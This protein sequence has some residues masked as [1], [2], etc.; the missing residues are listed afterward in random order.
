MHPNPAGLPTRSAQNPTRTNPKSPRSRKAS[1][2]EGAALPLFRGSQRDCRLIGW[3][4]FRLKLATVTQE[5]S[6]FW[7]APG[8]S[9]AGPSPS[10][11]L[12]PG[13]I[14]A[15]IRDVVSSEVSVG[16]REK[17][18]LAGSR[19]R[20]VGFTLLRKQ[21]Q[22]WQ[23]AS[24]KTARSSPVCGTSRSLPGSCPH[25]ARGRLHTTPG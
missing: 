9:G 21:L 16:Q 14:G 19:S 20:S 12:P 5:R 18:D 8:S 11:P 17:S 6:S 22:R 24:F 10:S 23:S 4:T 3:P 13:G 25:A 2:R 7:L 15:G 1:G